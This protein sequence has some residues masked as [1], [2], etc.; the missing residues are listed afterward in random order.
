[1]TVSSQPTKIAAII[2]LW[3]SRRLSVARRF[4]PHQAKT[5]MSTHLED[6][7]R[8]L[9]HN[10]NSNALEEAIESIRT[11]IRA[12]GDKP[13]ASMAKQ[14][15]ILEELAGFEFGRFLLQNNGWNG[16]WTHHILTHPEKGR[17][18]GL[19]H[20]GK[21]LTKMESFMLNEMPAVLATQ[22]RYGHFLAQNQQAVR[23]GAVLTCIPCGLMG[24]LLYLD[25]SD[26]E[27]FRLVG[28]DID[29]DALTGAKTLAQSLKLDQ[30]VELLEKDAWN[31]GIK[32]EFDLLSSNG[33]N[34]YEPDID[35]LTELYRQFYL[36]LKPG[37]K[38]VTSFLTYSPF[39]SEKSEW[40]MT[41]IN[42]EALLIQRI[43]FSDVLT[44]KWAS[45]CSSPE[46]HQQL[47]S[48]GFKSIRIIPDRAML[49]PTVV[50]IK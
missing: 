3:L 29:K 13:H 15:Q 12:A 46:M 30:N 11:R 48:V 50:A 36:A 38:L 37:G 43:I 41:K 35:K 23:S 39:N 14:L 32:D 40:D 45:F 28:I 16:Y 31:L 42:P 18:T 7:Q 26:V 47:A 27:N 9:S 21:P 34:V 25:Y 19:E 5:Y 20:D 33:L 2:L 6:S 1:M 22:E 17:K 4:K 8:T 24:E 49:F 44:P 10:P